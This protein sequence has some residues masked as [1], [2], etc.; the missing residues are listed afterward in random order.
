MIFS[1]GTRVLLKNT[2]DKGSIDQLL[3]ND[4]V[5]VKLDE[6]GMLIPV[7]PD[8][9]ERLVEYTPGKVPVKA[10]VV[11]GKKEQSS[12]KPKALRP[13]L[14]YTI[15]RS[16]GIQL[17]FEPLLNKDGTTRAYAIHLINDTRTNTV[18]SIKLAF[19][20]EDE[21]F[22]KTNGNLLAMSTKLLGEFSFDRLNDSPR[23]EVDCWEAS[24]SGKGEQHSKNIRIKA[25]QFFKKLKEA[26]LLNIPVHHYILF[27]DLSVN[28]KEE[29]E[30]E[31]DLKS[32]TRRNKRTVERLNDLY[33]YSSAADPGE[34]ARFPTE[35]DLHVEKLLPTKGKMSNAEKLRLQLEAFDD[36]LEEAIRLGVPKVF[37]IHGVGKGRL[38]DEIASRLVQNS[39]VDSFK[40]EY[41][42]AYG[43]GATEVLL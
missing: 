33:T 19:A 32:Y 25:K 42:H 21:Y 31:E 36:Y 2:G 16:M 8:D 34:R 4:M 18:F 26:P 41:H 1:I 30:E 22:L 37:I 12:E 10:K 14:Q 11:P 40:N 15:L 27:G 5:V 7:F 3:D 29:G 43:W 9:L 17:G 35:I 38:R 6:D 23:V 13:N 24:T 28:K 20:D 39:Y